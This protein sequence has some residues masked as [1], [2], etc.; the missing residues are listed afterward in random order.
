MGNEARYVIRY[1]DQDRNG[2]SEAR[3]ITVPAPKENGRRDWTVMAAEGVLK[4]Y[5][6][7]RTVVIPLARLISLDMDLP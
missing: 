2:Q 1:V 3:E 6:G 5:S 7:N 4:V